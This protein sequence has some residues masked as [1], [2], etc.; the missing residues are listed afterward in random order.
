MKTILVPTDFSDC[1]RYASDAAI[2]LAK[3]IEAELH[4][5]HFMSI[6]F[7]WSHLSS[8]ETEKMYPDV[9]RKVKNVQ[10]LLTK[11]VYQA[12]AAGVL[13]KFFIGYNETAEDIIDQADERGISMVIMGSHGS[14]GLKEFFIGSNAQKIVRQSKVP[15]FILKESLETIKVSNIL[16]VSNFEDEMLQPFEQVI[17]LARMLNA[18]IN[19]LYV[20]VPDA[21]SETWEIEQK[22]ESFIALAGDALDK[23]ETINTRLFENGVQRYCDANN[24]GMLAIATHQSRGLSRLFLGGIAEKVVNHINIPVMSIPVRERSGYPRL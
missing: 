14:K 1:A 15:V 23:A 6:P 24:E 10:H 3:V 20:N 21:F 16:F 9:T 11:L 17:V 22:M 13:A 19:L 5:Y 4:F 8:A 18:K 2:E 12:R 7:D